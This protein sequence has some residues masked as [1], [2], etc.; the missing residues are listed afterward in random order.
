VGLNLAG[1]QSNPPVAHN[2]PGLQPER[3]T[4]AWGR[5]ILSLVTIALISLRWAEGH[6]M[7]TVV[8]VAVS[9]TTALAIALTQRRRHL[10]ST[11]MLTAGRPASS[12][13]SV[14]GVAIAVVALGGLGL[15]VSS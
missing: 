9:I 4:L 6:A 13:G 12:V 15:L 2:D 10:R 7:A 3:T 14:L 1:A 11:Q 8:M 5:T